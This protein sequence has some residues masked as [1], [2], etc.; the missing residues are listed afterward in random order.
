MSNNTYTTNPIPNTYYYCVRSYNGKGKRYYF[1]SKFCALFWK[2]K[3]HPKWQ[4]KYGYFDIDEYGC[5]RFT[6]IEQ[7][8]GFDEDIE[9]N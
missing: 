9:E 8:G 7:T 4:M 3:T 5:E 6:T 1:K 2:S